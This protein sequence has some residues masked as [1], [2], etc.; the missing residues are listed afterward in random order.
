VIDGVQDPTRVEVAYRS[1]HPVLWRALVAYT[2]DRE[3]ASD[4]ESEAFAQVIR[5]GNEV[6]DVAAWVWRSAFAIAG[7]MLAARRAQ[8][9]GGAVPAEQAG[10]ESSMT[11]FISMLGALNGPQ[12]AC[13]VLRYVTQLDNAGIAAALGMREGTVRVQLHRAHTVLRRSLKEAEHGR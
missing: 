12:R 2:G 7:G 3:V 13:I 6:I 8:P 9:V 1:M 5:R 10:F 4:A 11:E